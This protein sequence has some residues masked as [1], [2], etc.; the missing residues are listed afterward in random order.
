[1]RQSARPDVLRDCHSYQHLLGVGYQLGEPLPA[2]AVELG[3][4]I[5]EHQHRVLAASAQQLVS[6]EPQGEGHRP[7]LAV[8]G[9]AAGRQP[10]DAELQLVAVRADQADCPL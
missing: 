9:V 2:V 1:M 4:D 6:G 10:A 7:G 5:V 8:A 3:E